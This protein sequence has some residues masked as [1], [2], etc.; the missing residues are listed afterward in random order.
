M[1]LDPPLLAP[2]VHESPTEVAVLAATFSYKNRGAS[3]F[4]KILA[5]LPGSDSSELP[6]AFCAITL[7]YTCE[8]HARLNGAA[9]STVEGTVQKITPVAENVLPSQFAMSCM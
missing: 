4:V 7:A 5:P 8:P 6:Y 3:G 9:F 1:T 2:R